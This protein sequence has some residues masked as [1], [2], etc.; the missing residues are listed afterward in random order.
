MRLATFGDRGHERLAVVRDGRLLPVDEMDDEAAGLSLRQVLERGWLSRLRDRAERQ[1]AGSGHPVDGVR[2]GP[3]LTDPRQIICVGLNYRGHA[4]EQNAP[5]PERPLLFSKSP[6]ALNGPR[7]AIPLPD[8][9]AL[10]DYE[11]ELAVVIG[12][13]TRR[14]AAAEAMAQV[15]GFCVANDVSARRWQKADGQ[16]FRAKSCD[17]FLPLG[18]CLVTPEEVGDW[19]QL[20]LTT[21]IGDE[22][23]QDALADELIHDIPALIA[24]ISRT[25]T[26]H[27]GDVIITGTPAGVGCYRTPKRFL[28]PGERVRCAITGLGELDNPVVADHA[29]AP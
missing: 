18:P 9:E 20:R 21:R 17:G 24:W 6:S 29:P 5:F 23:L 3:P 8:P 14:V 4:A 7:D 11:V 16:W 10:V 28:Q 13:T 25:T 12:R 1:P 22:L 15:A 27:P 2:L 19:H 26:L